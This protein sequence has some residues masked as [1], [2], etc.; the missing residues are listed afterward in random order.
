MAQLHKP[1]KHPSEFQPGEEFTPVEF[2]VSRGLV[3]YYLVG[4]NDRHP[5]YTEASPFDG[6]V[7]PPV[8]AH[9]YSGISRAYYIFRE[10]CPLH[11]EP[12]S[13]HYSYDAEYVDPIKV[14]EKI[15]VKGK[16]VAAYE[17]RGRKFSDTEYNVYGEDG[18]LCIHLLESHTWF[19]KEE[20]K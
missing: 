16:C 8:L 18:R 1:L 14:G 9:T 11:I 4:I 2:V 17:R 3:D 5:W 10:F 7:V 12:A 20:G 13:V 6:P 15:T 19:A